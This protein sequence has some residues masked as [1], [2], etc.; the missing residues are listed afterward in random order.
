M[1]I[2]GWRFLDRLW[3]LQDLFRDM[4][5]IMGWVEGF[6]ALGI[7]GFIYHRATVTR[8]NVLPPQLIELT[9]RSPS[10]S[11]RYVRF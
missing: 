2:W 1:E 7:V 8:Y 3:G 4:G 5:H 9:L 10:N 11:Q 6:R